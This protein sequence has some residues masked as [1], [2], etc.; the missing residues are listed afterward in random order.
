M[1]QSLHSSQS[2]RDSEPQTLSNL[3]N[4]SNFKM[5]MPWSWSKKATQAPGRAKGCLF[6]GLRTSVHTS[7]PCTPTLLLPH[8]VDS[9]GVWLVLAQNQPRSTLAVGALLPTSAVSQDPMPNSCEKNLP[10]PAYPLIQSHR[11]ETPGR[12]T[13]CYSALM[14]PGPVRRARQGPAQ[15]A[16]GGQ[17]RCSPRPRGERVKGGQGRQSSELESTPGGRSTPHQDLLAA[18]TLLLKET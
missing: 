17:G 13:Q 3:V 1:R 14:S 18:S 15:A 10:G 12:S 6:L 4:A 2:L 11:S 8:N 16:G 7:S 5:R 9:Q